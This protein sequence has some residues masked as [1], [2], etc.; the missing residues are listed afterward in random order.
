MPM[1]ASSGAMRGE[2]LQRPEAD[3]LDRHAEQAAAAIT[4]AS[5]VTGSGVPR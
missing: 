2:S 1:V 5:S 4:T 3:A